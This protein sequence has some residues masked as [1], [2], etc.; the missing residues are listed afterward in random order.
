MEKIEEIHDFGKI[1][2]KFYV[3]FLYVRDDV[4]VWSDIFLFG[5]CLGL[6]IQETWDQELGHRNSLGRRRGGDFLLHRVQHENSL[7]S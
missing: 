5:R 1:L 4:G 6:E 7:Y 2:E 3:V